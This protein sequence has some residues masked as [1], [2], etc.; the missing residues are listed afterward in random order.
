MTTTP[1]VRHT[2]PDISIREETEGLRY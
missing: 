1:A 2:V